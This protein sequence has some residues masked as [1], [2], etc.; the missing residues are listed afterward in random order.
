MRFLTLCASVG[1]KKGSVLLMHGVTMKFIWK[2]ILLTSCQCGSAEFKGEPMLVPAT[3][4][5]CQLKCRWS[6]ML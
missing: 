6:C 1:N 4:H 2:V 3:M 5:C